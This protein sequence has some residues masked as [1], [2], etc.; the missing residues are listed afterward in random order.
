MLSRGRRRLLLGSLVTAVAVSG[1]GAQPVFGPVVASS[2]A[3]AEP[4][5][6]VGA[7]PLVRP[8]RV[9][10]M[11]TARAAGKRVEDLSQGDAFTK[12]F[13]NPDGSWTSETTPGPQRVRDD[14]GEWVGVDLTL[15]EQGG[16]LVPTAS[17]VELSFSA[18]GDRAFAQ[19]TPAASEVGGAASTSGDVVWRWPTVLPEPVLDGATATYPDAVPG[20]GDLVV[21][22]TPTGFTHNI[23]LHEAPVISPGEGGASG[24]AAAG[25]VY[26][27]PVVTPGAQ[28]TAAVG[29]SLGVIDTGGVGKGEEVA[30]AP[31]PLMWDSSEDPGSGD[32][33]VEPV[34]VSV[35][36]SATA[37][38]TPVG[39]M[40]LVPS[41][42][43]LT[44]PDT[45][46][47]VTIDPTFEM[48]PWWDTW[49]STTHTSGQSSNTHLRVGKPDAST[50]ARSF[51]RFGGDAT[52][53]GNQIVSAKLV[54]RNFFSDSCAA[55][56]VR[57]APISESW[58]A[59]G[60]TWS[61]QPAALTTE[62]ADYSAAHGG[63]A[64]CGA[65]DAT[66]D[67]R[68]MVRAWSEDRYPNWGIRLVAVN[69]STTDTYRMYRSLDY[70]DASVAPRLVVTY[71]RPPAKPTGV[72]PSPFASYAR[73]GGTETYRYI[74]T[75]TPVVSM[76]ATDADGGTVQGR[77]RVYAGE[78]MGSTLLGSCTTGWV[79]QGTT[80]SCTMPTLPN[81]TAIY[82]R[83]KAKDSKGYWAG[84]SEDATTGW[85]GSVLYHV[86]ATK[87]TAPV[88]SCPTPY[89]NDSWHETAPGA[90]VS[91]T[92][93]AAASGLSAPGYIR[94][95]LNG[96]PETR[97]KI[98]PSSNPATAKI[99]IT[100]PNDLG[101]YE[102]TARAE[103]RSGLISEAA[104]YG[105]GYG[106]FTMASPAPGVS[107]RAAVTTTDRVTLV[108]EG[109][110][111]TATSP[112]P[113]VKWRVAGSGDDAATGWHDAGV[114]DYDT[115]T[116][117]TGKTSVTAVVDTSTFDD[118]S[119]GPSLRRPVMLELQICMPYPSTTACTWS[120]APTRVLRLPS[121]FG[122]NYPV[123]EAGPGEVAL[124]TG[125][126]GLSE[127]DATEPGYGTELGV[128]RSH[129]SFGGPAEDLGDDGSGPAGVFGPGWTASLDGP[130]YGLSGATLIDSTPEDGTLAL[131]T[132]TGDALVWSK[133]T[134]AAKRT[135]QVLA[136]GGWEPADDATR[137]SDVKL[138]VTGTGG[139]TKVE[140]TEPDGTIT[141]FAVTSA[142]TAAAEYEFVPE[143]V[144]DPT[145]AGAAGRTTF[146]HDSDG[147]VTRILSPVP[148]GVTCPTVASGDP[149]AAGCHALALT[150]GDSGNS[151][152]RLTA[153]HV[154]HG[155]TSTLVTSY[156]YDAHGRLTGVSDERTGLTTT[157]TWDGPDP[158]ADPSADPAAA[159]R[160]ASY[161][162]PGLKTVHLDYDSDGRLSKVSRDNPSDAGTTTLAQVRYTIPTQ[163]SGATA[164]GLPVLD[165]SGVGV[166]N[167]A[168]V[169]TY[170]AAV[171][172]QGAPGV[173]ANPASITA[174]E[175]KHASVS[176]TDADGRTLN[177]AVYGAGRW[178][179]SA[180][181][182]DSHEN[183]IR[184][185]A[186]GDIA[187]IQDGEIV[188]ADA[189][190][191]NVYDEVKDPAGNVTIP[192]GAVLTENFGPARE[193]VITDAGG[194]SADT[195]WVR[196]H[197]VL[198]YD[199]GAP[200]NGINPATGTAYGLQTTS[201]TRPWDP[202]TEADISGAGTI[203]TE[204]R[205]GYEALVAGDKTGWELGAPT[206]ST[207]V[208]AS[209]QADI[210]TRTRYDAEG[211]VI[212]NRQPSSNGA[213]AGTRQTIYY[214]A[215]ANSA[216]AACG[217]KPGW[218]GLVCVTQYAGTSGSGL[219]AERVTDYNADLQPL[220]VTETVNGTLRRTTTT[221]YDSAGRVAKNWSRTHAMANSVATTGTLTE[222]DP[223]T[224]HLVTVKAIDNTGTVLT[225]KAVAHGYDGWGRETSYSVD[226]GAG[227]GP[228]VTT[229]SYNAAGDVDTV[230]DP[231]GTTTYTYDG[232]DADGN[233]E[234]RG[235][236]TKVAT[237]RPIAADVE[238]T[239]AYNA[240]GTLVTHKMPGG[241]IQ[242]TSVNTAGELEG[243]SYGGRV[244]LP[245][246]NDPDGALVPTDDIAWVGWSQTSDIFGRTRTEWTPEGAAFTGAL[247]GSNAATAYAR[248]YTYDRAGRLT[249]V[250]DHT[251]PNGGGTTTVENGVLTSPAGTVCQT[252]TYGFDTN[253]NRT[254]LTSKGANSD[255]T[256]NSSISR[257]KTW[258]WDNADRP[259]NT[260]Y[261]I[262]PLGRITTI[263]A[264]DTPTGTGNISLAYYDT[265]TVQTI[266]TTTSGITQ[267]S[268]Y[269]L[270]PVGRRATETTTET[271][272]AGTST[273]TVDLHYTGDTDNPAWSRLTKNAEATTTRYVDNLAGDLTATLVSDG[274]STTV[275]ATLALALANPHGDIVTTV[276]IPATGPATG[277]NPWTSYDEYGS[278]DTPATTPL[279]DSGVG[280]GWV[281]NKQRATQPHGLILMGARPY[282]PTTGQFTSRDPIH[283]GNTTTYTYPTDP[284]NLYD[285]SGERESPY[286]GMGGGGRGGGW[287]GAAGGRSGGGKSYVPWAKQRRGNWLIRR[288]N[289]DDGGRL[290]RTFSCRSNSFVAVTPVLLADGTRKRISDIKLGDLVTATNPLTGETTARRVTRVII[291]SGDKELVRI[292][293]DPDRD[294]QEEWIVATAGHPFWAPGRGWLDANDLEVGDRLLEEDGGLVEVV[295]VKHFE[296]RTTVYNL[297]V[298]AVHT[299]WVSFNTSS[300]LVHNCAKKTTRKSGKEKS[301]DLPTH[302]R[303]LKPNAN[304]NVD[305]ALRRVLGRNAERGPGSD[306]NKLRKYWHRNGYR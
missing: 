8:D 187:A 175:W 47:P 130:G 52:W 10:A 39:T 49:V 296:A 132:D 294:G 116:P 51:L 259:T 95:S 24:D 195:A 35:V 178:L 290:K 258:T 60:V 28:L 260:G 180:A 147:R 69:E 1:F 66:W 89:S 185:L 145:T 38:G 212:E 267:A 204:S 56:A 170:G 217:N 4:D 150:Y 210:V 18:G 36:A 174:G 16:R 303:G 78:S 153:I 199:E 300:V 128:S 46:Y 107:G 239:G 37:N 201:A 241:L 256:C 232:T 43:F 92:I 118:G 111:N 48:L 288:Y 162:P 246:P 93:T 280:Y 293:I 289:N 17:L 225:G 235:L 42:E 192:A 67:V 216:D 299:Y 44:D 196:P 55:G 57:A 25:P 100:V 245:D 279:T 86:A 103:S 224:G 14:A 281:G 9:S 134:P 278:P 33:V 144:Q 109:P 156:S 203:L 189:G 231:R 168:V 173:D 164:A 72:V 136:T 273:S 282:N 218:A 166:W 129:G 214:T 119:G 54:L 266:T 141:I 7:G 77:I 171:F 249:D 190:T 133:T 284:V 265:D 101:A 154:V 99:D 58:T 112:E 11:V 26:E 261:D 291:G 194:L 126:F 68:P 64:S 301:N 117:A 105:F 61:D 81:D 87:P 234:H 257:T 275:D 30:S 151:T 50:R 238:F 240:D 76:K 262:D 179:L 74:P 15:V 272:T 227:T 236:A 157:Y 205:T 79:A 182:Y 172:P 138:A 213:D 230:T 3:A 188:A 244:S 140:I 65:A 20:G 183:V 45:V 114:S 53:D 297:T 29:G 198:S 97:T 295:G 226:N 22:A 255:G 208:M 41:L 186:A 305:N 302:L 243:S 264:A 221:T 285:L 252:R 127:T 271:T 228:E 292:G 160:I 115:A 59:A 191:I 197:T 96:A 287:G 223:A 268:T 163:G 13:A 102:I 142:V 148:D 220:E 247:S 143:S 149:L 88:I 83:A 125:E 253:G 122:G 269:S 139:S 135:D 207:T 137:L 124:W 158:S 70:S 31:A 250:V 229:T 263:P 71:N 104:T 222:Y 75:R 251:A 82:V 6:T 169:P 181:D 113:V 215:G 277:I 242:R 254:S 19:A 80:G 286:V 34:E 73:P 152:D 123:A 176:Y 274:T 233:E 155:A 211:R 23:V 306:W 209:G 90:D 84:G 98:T 219:P 12:V 32:P 91:C 161:T 202:G 108:A 237:S 248:G 2:A 304:E 165:A 177:T 62:N 159:R 120:S 146:T 5:D 121:A 193:A 167:Q 131:L 298:H 184:S 94:W 106:P 200:N 206:T 21:I 40:R 276:T 270:D 110:T 63:G 283:G 85:S 27:I